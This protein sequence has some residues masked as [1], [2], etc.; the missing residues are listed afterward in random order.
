MLILWDSSS[1]IVHIKN[2]LRAAPYLE[3]FLVAK[4]HVAEVL[5]KAM[6]NEQTGSRFTFIRFDISLS[7]EVS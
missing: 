7:C 2:D 5:L 1:L 6:I 4:I 3:F